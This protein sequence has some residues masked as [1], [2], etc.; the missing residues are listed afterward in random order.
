MTA[1]TELTVRVRSEI[2]EI[3]SSSEE[4]EKLITGQQIEDALLV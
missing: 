1:E 4:D 2:R 3:F